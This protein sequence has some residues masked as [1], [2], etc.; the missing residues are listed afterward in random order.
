MKPSFHKNS[1]HLRLKGELEREGTCHNWS[2]TTRSLVKSNVD[3]PHL[4]HLAIHM[5]M[6][7]LI[8]HRML[9]TD[10]NEERY[11]KKTW[12]RFTSSLRNYFYNYELST[13]SLGSNV[14]KHLK[15]PMMSDYDVLISWWLWRSESPW[16]CLE[17]WPLSR[18][19]RWTLT[20][21][22]LFDAFPSSGCSFFLQKQNNLDNYIATEIRRKREHFAEWEARDTNPNKPFFSG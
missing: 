19:W 17:Q 1:L 5:F 2:Q 15:K 3:A 22:L 10:D 13:P 9:T 20:C 11:I 18:L 14:Y 4:A 12:Y 16:I 7:A 21:S 8:K 6:S